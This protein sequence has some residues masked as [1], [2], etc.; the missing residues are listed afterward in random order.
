MCHHH[1]S[2]H[3]STVREFWPLVRGDS[4][5]QLISPWLKDRRTIVR[6]L[7][8][9]Y[10]KAAV[11]LQCVAVCCSVLQC[12]AVCCSVLQ[13][14]DNGDGPRHNRHKKFWS[15]LKGL[16]QNSPIF[17]FPV[18]KHKGALYTHSKHPYIHTQKS[19]VHTLKR[20]LWSD[21]EFPQVPIP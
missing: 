21:S 20:A 1:E 10:T 14:R 8:K 11:V 17:P 15:F 4:T 9:M 5:N 13:L 6:A 18:D 3:D 2:L 16:I 19:P 12:V 7:V